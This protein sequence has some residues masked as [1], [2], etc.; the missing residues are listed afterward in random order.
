MKEQDV[1]MWAEQGANDDDVSAGGQSSWET[2]SHCLFSQV[3]VCFHVFTC[4]T[5]NKVKYFIA[6]LLKKN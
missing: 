3:C 1:G 6:E 2:L 4:Y 5:H